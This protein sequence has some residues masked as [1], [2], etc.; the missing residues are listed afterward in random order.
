MKGRQKWPEKPE[1]FQV[2]VI[3]ASFCFKYSK[4]NS[5]LQYLP[6]MKKYE[7]RLLLKVAVAF[8]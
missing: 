2:S 3:S 7:I 8:R 1:K 4:I 5:L 6:C